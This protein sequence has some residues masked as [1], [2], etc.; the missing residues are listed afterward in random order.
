MRNFVD[1]VS[2]KASHS[3]ALVCTLSTE[4]QIVRCKKGRSPPDWA[5]AD[6]RCVVGLSILGG[7]VVSLLSV[8][9][10]IEGE[11]NP[12]YML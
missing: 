7:D 5:D 1:P 3:T 2:T 6:I 12:G 10:L 4:G 11:D 9:Q 8:S